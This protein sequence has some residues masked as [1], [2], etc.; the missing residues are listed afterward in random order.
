MF[1]EWPQVQLFDAPNS[2]DYMCT[3]CHDAH[4][5]GLNQNRKACM[6]CHN[7]TL[8]AS[9]VGFHVGLLEKLFPTENDGYAMLQHKLQYIINIHN[10]RQASFPGRI[11]AIALI[12]VES[13][14]ILLIGNSA[15]FPFCLGLSLIFTRK[16]SK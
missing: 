5:G 6:V 9:N 11:G 16:R 7:Q 14:F 13:V 8:H 2:E 10:L 12:S 1:R 4:G 3:L 15:L